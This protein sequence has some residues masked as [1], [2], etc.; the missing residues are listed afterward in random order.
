MPPRRG[1]SSTLAST[2]SVLLS[3][4]YA[5][6]LPAPA[7]VSSKISASSLGDSSSFHEPEPSWTPV[8]VRAR[9]SCI[10][11]AS[12]EFP[13]SKF[14]SDSAPS[15]TPT[16]ETLTDGARIAIKLPDVRTRARYFFAFVGVYSNSSGAA[17][18]VRTPA[19]STAHGAAPSSRSGPRAV[20][21]VG[22]LSSWPGTTGRVVSSRFANLSNR[23]RWRKYGAHHHALSS[24]YTHAA[25]NS[26]RAKC[27]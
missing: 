22:C 8:S 16:A 9:A 18:T 13:S 10:C 11:T 1:S 26:S 21:V 3:A 20:V 19:R 6:C 14:S 4:V 15:E 2:G 12:S 17:L 23:A 7:C 24:M 27:E 25:E 5:K